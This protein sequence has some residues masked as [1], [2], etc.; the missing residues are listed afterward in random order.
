MDGA[1]VPSLIDVGYRRDLEKLAGTAS[2][3]AI[4]AE[5]GGEVA[6]ALA[7][8]A[9]VNRALRAPVDGRL[10]KI[11]SVS[12]VNWGSRLR[13]GE[14]EWETAVLGGL[15]AL[16]VPPPAEPW[17]QATRALLRALTFR[18]ETEQR[19]DKLELARELEEHC[20]VKTVRET[21][22]AGAERR[23][24]SETFC[25]C[26]RMNVGR[27][28]RGLG[29][30]GSLAA[31]CWRDHEPPVARLLRGELSPTDAV[32]DPDALALPRD[33][34]LRAELLS[35]SEAALAASRRTKK[36]GSRMYRCPSCGA[37]DSLYEE[38]QTRG[39]DEPGTML[40]ECLNCG[41]HF[42]GRE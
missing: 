15:A 40:C 42:R 5:A 30:D 23:W 39:T 28:C 31:G 20:Y 1:D 10:S 41:N 37:R 2:A 14:V 6:T 12:D 16:L 13:D 4:L 26:Y 8:I 34:M 9:V 38:H 17:D 21:T 22:A 3:D 7:A 19:S 32:N 25:T 36:K 11:E 35:R 18:D 29:G 24:T 33:Q 27:V